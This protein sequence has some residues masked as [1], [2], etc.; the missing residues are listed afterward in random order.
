MTLYSWK[1]ELIFQL[2]IEKG[3]NNITA[4]FMNSPHTLIAHN[5][6]DATDAGILSSRDATSDW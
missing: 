3:Q 5:I 4:F 1:Q 2:W 6:T